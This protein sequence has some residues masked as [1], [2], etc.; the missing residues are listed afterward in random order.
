M[1]QTRY[2]LVTFNPETPLEQSTVLI[3]KRKNFIMK[4]S[5]N[6][7]DHRRHLNFYDLMVIGSLE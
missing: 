6:S 4:S 3:N 2:L 5:G 7:R 1:S